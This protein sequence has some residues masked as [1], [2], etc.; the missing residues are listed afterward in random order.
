MRLTRT[1]D[2]AAAVLE[3]SAPTA[4]RILAEWALWTAMHGCHTATDDCVCARGVGRVRTVWPH[5]TTGTAGPR[6]G[7]PGYV[8]DAAKLDA[9]AARLRVLEGREAA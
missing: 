5:T 2:E 4:R 3:C 8:T 9:H 7:R 1:T 6:G